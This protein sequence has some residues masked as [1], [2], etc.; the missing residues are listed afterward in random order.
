MR[1]LSIRA[2]KYCKFIQGFTLALGSHK[3]VCN[4]NKREKPCTLYVLPKAL[5]PVC[6]KYAAQDG[7]YSRGENK[8]E[9]F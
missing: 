7:K 6:I 2:N 8:V 1:Q 4:E 5:S 3:K 9:V